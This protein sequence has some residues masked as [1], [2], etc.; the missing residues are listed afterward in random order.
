MGHFQLY[1]QC[2]NC[3]TEAGHCWCGV[4]LFVNNTS[5]SETLAGG[6]NVTISGV[7]GPIPANSTARGVLTYSSST[8]V[9]IQIVEVAYNTAGGYDPSTVQTQFGSSNGT[10]LEEG[11][12]YRNI[13]GAGINPASTNADIVL[14]VYSMPANAFDGIGNRGLGLTAYGSFANNTNSKRIKIWFNATTA[15]VGSAVTGGTAVVD[16]GAYTT[17][18]AA[19]WEMQATVFKYGASGSNTQQAMSGGVFIGGTHTGVGAGSSVPQNLTATE[20]GVILIAVTGN[21]VTTATDIVLNGF[22]VNAMN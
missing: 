13:S 12:L 15:T 5:Y 18:G 17:T 20:S 1:L 11:N 16:T 10:F 3:V 6:T 14:A 21:A 8:A 22:L 4:F 2:F 9:T 19:G 7:T